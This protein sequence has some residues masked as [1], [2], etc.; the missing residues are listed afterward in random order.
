MISRNDAVELPKAVT[1]TLI[2]SSANLQTLGA[3]YYQQWASVH[4]KSM[5]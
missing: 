2:S 4:K 1:V 5:L 3:G